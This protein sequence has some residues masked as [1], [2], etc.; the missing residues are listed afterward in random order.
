MVAQLENERKEERPPCAIRARPCPTI[1][2]TLNYWP[3]LPARDLDR[4]FFAVT[5][6]LH[7]VHQQAH[8]RVKARLVLSR[9]LFLPFR[10]AT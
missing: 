9:A 8:R 4:L 6:L 3:A 1:H 7:L 5:A 10:L 2:L